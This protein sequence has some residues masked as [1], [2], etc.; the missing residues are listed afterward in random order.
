[1]ASLRIATLNV[2]GLKD[3]KRKN[4]LHKFIKEKEIDLIALQEVNVNDLEVPKDYNSVFNYNGIGPGTAV[5]YNKNLNLKKRM[6]EPSGRIIKLEFENFT[7]IN[8]YGPQESLPTPIKTTFYLETLPKYLKTYRE[9]LILLGDFN[10]TT[11]P[12]DREGPN[13]VNG[14]LKRLIERLKL[15]DLYRKLNGDNVDYTFVSRNGKTRIDRIYGEAEIVKKVI[16]CVHLNYPVSDHRAVLIEMTHN[17]RKENAPKN[18]LWKMNTSILENADLKEIIESKIK[19]LN[20]VKE[21]IFEQW[22]KFKLEVKIECKKLSKIQAKEKKD[23]IKFYEACID[24]LFKCPEDP[25]FY[26]VYKELKSRILNI[27]NKSSNACKIRGKPTIEIKNEEP[28]AGHL[29]REKVK[30]ENNTISHML[31]DRNENLSEE[32]KIIEYVENCYVDLYKLEKYDERLRSSWLDNI[33]KQIDEEDNKDLLQPITKQELRETLDTTNEK[34]SPGPDGITYNFYKTFWNSL[35]PLVVNLVNEMLTIGATLDS[36]KYG[37]IKLIPK[38]KE[39][40]TIDDYR[41]IS[42][43]NADYRIYAKIIANR[44]RNSLTNVIS[45]AQTGGVKGRDIADNLALV[46]NTIQYADGKTKKVAIVSVDFKKA[47]DMVERGF[48]WQVMEKYGYS[49]QFIKILQG[50]YEQAYAKIQINGKTGGPI[51]LERG[52]RQG[53]PLA[54]YLYIIYI[55]PL[56]RKLEADLHGVETQFCK[57]ALSAYVDD[58]TVYTGKDGDFKKLENALIEFGKITNAKINQ[59]K[60][61]VMGLGGYKNQ[62]EW[63]IDWLKSSENIELLGIKWEKTIKR[64]ITVN[65]NELSNK[66]N[67]SILAATERHLTVLQKVEFANMQ[68]LPKLTYFS[69]ILPFSVKFYKRTT[70]RVTNFIWNHRVER[71]A[72]S[73]L[74]NLKER[75]G[76]NLS[77]VKSKCLANFLKTSF[78][79]WQS[80]GINGKFLEHWIGRSLGEG[81]RCG[82]PSEVKRSSA[83]SPPSFLQSQLQNFKNLIKEKILAPSKIKTK[84][85]YNFLLVNEIKI[86]KILEKAV[87]PST[88]LKSFKI[89]HKNKLISPQAKEFCYFQLHNILTT[90]DRLFRCRQTNCMR[91]DFCPE[92]DN[93]AHIYNCIHSKTQIECFEKL[94]KKLDGKFELAQIDF[95]NQIC[96][97]PDKKENKFTHALLAEFSFHLFQIRKK[98]IENNDFKTKILEIFEKWKI[99]DKETIS[100]ID[101]ILSTS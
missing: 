93:V 49:E 10:A 80:G 42:L 64:T 11:H 31:N 19:E 97:L 48:L 23:L 62:I 45:E 61:I 9:N 85:I 17:L 89:L 58:V 78:R 82:P 35:E 8:I 81:R 101:K 65:E 83:K 91:C 67:G 28:N 1:M 95:P 22:E 43:L 25:N 84:E 39:A 54:L 94:I 36:H 51:P 90:K 2:R 6:L 14:K 87:K 47:F 66:V 27:E 34:S 13:R 18:D 7:V 60:T 40:K 98:E 50:T 99:I 92:E 76:L 4:Y 26:V 63:P 52:I 77:A 32:S 79:H 30:S 55:N 15:T 75:G 72:V 68:I 24:D 20:S 86:P 96:N 46:R 44:L 74:Y 100:S 41:P 70:A 12:I 37:L 38:K 16:S 59:Q 57:Y 5:I 71:L 53:C 3:N 33:T 88:T 69:R 56:I 73:E 29:L 21:N